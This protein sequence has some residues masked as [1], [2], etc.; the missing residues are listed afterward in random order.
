MKMEEGDDI[1]AEIRRLERELEMNEDKN[2]SRV[3]CLESKLR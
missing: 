2:K 1:E 3:A